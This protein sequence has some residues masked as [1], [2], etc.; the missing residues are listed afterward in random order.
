MI[1]VTLK[2]N[3]TNV[4]TVGT[5]VMNYEDSKCNKTGQI[6]VRESVFYC[7]LMGSKIA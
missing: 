3:I 7:V 4:C 2:V 1:P 6:H 5:G